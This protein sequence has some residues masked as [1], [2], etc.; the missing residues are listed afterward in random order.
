MA[1]QGEEKSAQPAALCDNRSERARELAAQGKKIIGYLCGFVPPELITA[2][3]MVPYRITGVMGEPLVEALDYFEPNACNY[4]LNCFQQAIK[5]R[6]D[7]LDGIVIPHA[8]DTVQRLYGLWK[9]W[10]PPAYAHFLNVPTTVSPASIRFFREELEMLK[11]SL[12][13]FGGVEITDQRLKE[14]LSLHNENRRL[15]A[16]LYG[17]RKEHP[18]ALTGGEMTRLLVAGAGIPADEFH[19]LLKEMLRSIGGNAGSVDEKKARVLLYG[20]VMDD[21]GLVDLIEAGGGSVVL[22][23][24]CIGTRSFGTA[25]DAGDDPME[26]LCRMYFAD[27]LCPKVVRSCDE[28]RFEYLV[29]M[30]REY[31]VKGVIGYFMAWCDPHKFDQPV[32]RNYL[33]KAGLPFLALEDDY[34]LS[35]SGAMQNRVQAFLEMLQQKD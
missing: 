9:F 21:A 10:K 27:F 8:C 35:S 5:G 24:T 22:D 23:D 2:A 17:M 34:T 11:E 15:V 1:L 32:L 31:R 29:Q 19:S 26:A 25:G 4:V 18:P 20:C 16:E 33:E 14:A 28:E 7:F 12:E 3:G 6:Y 30:A 13:S